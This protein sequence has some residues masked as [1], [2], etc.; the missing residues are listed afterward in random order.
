MPGRPPDIAVGLGKLTPA[1]WSRAWNAVMN[2]ES[3]WPFLRELKARENKEPEKTSFPALILGYKAITNAT[4][5]WAYAWQEARVDPLTGKYQPFMA[6]W[7]STVTVPGIPEGTD[8]PFA[9]PAYNRLET[10][11]DGIGVESGGVNVDGADYPA[12]WYVQPIR[13]GEADAVMEPAEE[14][15]WDWTIAP[16]VRMDVERDATGRPRVMFELM[17]AHDGT[18]PPPPP[19]PVA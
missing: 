15:L 14:E 10:G 12:T 11:N 13:G 1:R 16:A 9:W 4:N 7:R 6:G 5:R 2:F 3:V 19:E 18:C 17:N 8:E